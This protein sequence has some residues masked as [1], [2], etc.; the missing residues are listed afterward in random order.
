MRIYIVN[1]SHVSFGIG[2]ITPR[3]LYVLASATPAAHGEPILVDETLEPFDVGVVGPGDVVGIGIHTGNA[4]RGYEIGTIARAAGATVIFGGIH[5]TLYPDE[6]R[7][8]GGAHAVVTGDGELAWPAALDDA[9]RGQLRERYDG[10]R[11]GG[12]TF[13]PGRWELLPPGR[14]MWASV[15]TVRGCPKHCSFCS[16]WRTDGQQPRQ[17]HVA[18]VVEEIVDLRRRGFRFIALADDNFY[19][20]TPDDLRMAARRRDKADLQRLE[21]IRA[22]RFALMD[23]LAQLPDDTVFF[24]QITMEAGEDVEFLDGMQRAHIKGALVGVEAVTPE[25]LKDVYKNFNASGD[26]LVE[27]LKRFREHG[28]HVLGS[29]IFGLPSDRPES[30]AATLAV[31][32]RADLTFAQFVMLTPFPGT[33]DFAAWEKSLGA[34]PPSVDGIPVSRH[35]LIPQAVRPKVYMA[36]PVMTADEIRERTQAVW[37]RFYSLPTIWRRSRRAVT[38]M[39]GRL[40]FVLISKIYRQMYANTGIATDSARVNRS[41]RWARAMAIPCRRLFA[42]RPMPDLRVPVSIDPPPVETLLVLNR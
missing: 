18:R 20:V 9:A 16:V 13:L 41:A 26:T 22:E 30:F 21:A 24:T 10:G 12:D 11:I 32:E 25:G 4:L 39:R 19:P 38:S 28:I 23:A 29:F 37:D 27:R 7:Q 42:G 1:P 33:L 40:A 3:W 31:A 17:R 14:Y 5:A 35:W 15:Q 34:D 6:A 2:V 8:L 36:H